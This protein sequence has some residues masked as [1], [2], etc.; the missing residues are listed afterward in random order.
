MR[1]F[2]PLL[3]LC[4]TALSGAA[5]VHAA[6]LSKGGASMTLKLE[7]PAFTDNGDMPSV[8]TCDGANASPALAWSGV[9][10]GTESLALIV[11]DPD[12]PDP[13]A[14]KMTYVHWV[15]FNIPPDTAGL[16]QGVKQLPAG[17]REGVNDSGRTGY[18]GPCPPIGVHR[19]F[20]KLYALDTMLDLKGAPSKH[21][22]ETAMKEHIL[23]Q[24]T[25]VGH[26]K[27]GK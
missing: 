14:P 16:P 27:R 22:L 17:A 19:Y 18:T 1:L 12:A 2:F 20:H 8:C 25:L 3:A 24:A 23:A 21:E 5:P 26:Y 4:L 9:P 13:D 11:D 7:S 6:G 10:L 15:L